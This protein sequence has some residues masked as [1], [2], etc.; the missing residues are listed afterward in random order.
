M[1]TI[2]RHRSSITGKLVKEEYAKRHRSTTEREV[3]KIKK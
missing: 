3:Y 2:V 1:T